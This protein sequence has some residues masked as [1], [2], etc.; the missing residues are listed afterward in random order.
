MAVFN[1]QVQPT[2]DPNYLNIS[3]PISDVTADKSGGMLMAA[4]G[5]ALTGTVELVDRTEKDYLKD[6]IT[7]DV[8]GLQDNYITG[9]KGARGA[10]IAGQQPAGLIPEPDPATLAGDEPQVPAG[11]QQGIQRAQ[12]LAEARIQNG[13]SGKANDTLYAGALYS[14]TKQLRTE[15]PGYIDYIDQQIAKVSGKDPANYFMQNILQ[16]INASATNSKSE[17]D[18]TINLGRQWLG[19]DEHMPAYIE[20]VRRG[21]PGSVQN[22]EDRINTIAADKNNFDKWQRNR[23]QSQA[24][25]EDDLITNKDQFSK[26][27]RAKAYTLYNGVVQIPGLTNPTTIGKLVADAQEGR[28]SLTDAQWDALLPAAVAAQQRYQESAKEISDNRGYSTKIPNIKDRNDIIQNEGQIYSQIIDAIKAKDTGLMFA[29]QRR[30]Q[31]I[32]SGA[33]VQILSD[34]NLG[35]YAKNMAAFTKFGGPNWVNTAMGN[36]L[37]KGGATNLKNFLEDEMIKAQTPDPDLRDPSKAK[38]LYDA[39]QKAK[40][41]KIPASTKVYEDLIDNVNTINNPKA[42]LNVKAEVVNYVFKPKNWGVM[43][44]FGRD[45]TDNKG[46]FHSGKF[47]VYDIMTQPKITDNIW[48]SKDSTS[49][50][51][52]KN[53]QEQSFKKLFGEEV[54]NLVKIQGDKSMDIKINWDADHKQFIAEFPKATTNIEANYINYAQDSIKKLN[55]GLMNLSYMK[56]REGTDTN[57]YLADVLMGIG[58]SPNDRLHGDNLPQRFIEAIAASHKSNRIEDAFKAAGGSK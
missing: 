28:V 56:D 16:D 37:Q 41:A 52:Y 18:K 4:A 43:D 10:Q 11:V 22:L 42:P 26:E 57:A 15:N 5:E 32:Q 51:Y 46:V 1:P 47:A 48:Q 40:D 29:Q 33:E 44:Q 19:Y 53:W 2:Q 45:F 8:Q 23:T 38:S 54:Q 17:I 36:F 7:T 9:L 6:K 55:R 3:R 58:Y 34:P 49:W 27:L 31:S 14:Y 35:P 13:G 20:A 30:A 24:N 50:D 12:Q 25:I 21:L 39:I